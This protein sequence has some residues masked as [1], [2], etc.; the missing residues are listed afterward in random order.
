MKKQK[1][2]N[3]QIL[4]G[5]RDGLPLA[6]IY[7]IISFSFG[8][9]TTNKGLPFWYST[10][11]SATNLTSAG[12]FAGV[13]LIVEGTSYI[14]LIVTMLLINARYVLMG[15]SISR[16]LDKDLNWFQR[17]VA[18]LFL[19]DE[20]YAL[21]A[22]K[23]HKINFSYFMSLSIIPYLAWVLGTLT[24]GLTKDFFPAQFQGAM[25]I[26]LYCMF[27]GIIIPPAKKSKSIALCIGISALFSC[28]FYFTPY[29]NKISIGF[30][31]IIATL[32]ATVICALL[33][34]VNSLLE[35]RSIYSREELTANLPLNVNKDLDSKKNKEANPN[36]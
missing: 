25:G 6:F 33:F 11:I 28:I 35:D 13:N 24:G 9:A 18:G 7:F 2:L 32:L 27:I 23:S 29:I 31:A 1:R 14:A 16:Q 17:I 30:R 8:V 36:V 22:T 10:L 15:L 5:L 12:Q 26:A 20:I 21:I 3:S 19:T 4:N 34:P